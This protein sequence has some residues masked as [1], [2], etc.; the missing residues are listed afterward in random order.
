MA[1]K[2]VIKPDAEKELREAL[3]WYDLQRDGLG[4]E[5]YYEILEIMEKIKSNP[6]H[7]Q[8]RYK[9]FRISFTKRFKYGV[10]YT[11]EGEVVYVHA[12]LHTSKRP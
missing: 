5:L 9:D 3:V 4:S 8:K 7:F 11:V 6:N 12:I 1:Y 10:H 2:L